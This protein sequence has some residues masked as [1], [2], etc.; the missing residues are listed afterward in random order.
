MHGATHPYILGHTPMHTNIL[1]DW[2]SLTSRELSLIADVL[3]EQPNLKRNNLITKKISEKKSFL[4]L[5]CQ[6]KRE[7]K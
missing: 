1:F 3:D 4:R 6:N 7:T 2:N 5:A